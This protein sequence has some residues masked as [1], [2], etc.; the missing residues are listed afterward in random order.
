MI[1]DRGFATIGNILEGIQWVKDDIA[2]HNGRRAVV[3]LS[4]GSPMSITLDLAVQDLID[5]GI[6]VVIAA[7]N[8]YSDACNFSPARVTSAI[9]V[10]ALGR[11]GNRAASF[12]NQG[13]CVD[14]FAP[15]EDIPSVKNVDGNHYRYLDGT[16]MAAPLVAGVVANFLAYQEAPVSVD[17]VANFIS[18]R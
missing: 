11:Y 13:P 4:L 14:V 16:S 2:A 6:P 10:A 15:G 18:S 9:T 7:G 3:N 8:D 1:N 17:G 12:S 5:A